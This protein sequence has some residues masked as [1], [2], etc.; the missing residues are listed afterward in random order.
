M[1]LYVRD[2]LIELE[3][4]HLKLEMEKFLVE[5]AKGRASEFRERNNINSFIKEVIK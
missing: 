3:L 2:V 4:T 1:C 5:N